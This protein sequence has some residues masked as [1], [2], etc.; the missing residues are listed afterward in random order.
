MASRVHEVLRVE[1]APAVVALVAAG[2]GVATVGAFSLHVAVGQVSATVAAVGQQHGVLVNEPLL[3]EFEEEVLGHLAMIVGAGGG[4]EV[5][6][7]AHPLPRVEEVVVI[8]VHHLLGRQPFLLGPYGDGRAM[9]VATG[10][11]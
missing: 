8:L 3:K 4:E 7:D 6:A 1:S 11:H 9:L 2:P 10:D 5:E